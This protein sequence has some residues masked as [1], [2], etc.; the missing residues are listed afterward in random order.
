M[1]RPATAQDVKQRLEHFEQH[2]IHC[3]SPIATG[4][5]ALRLD[6]FPRHGAAPDVYD[7]CNANPHILP[8]G[9]TLKGPGGGRGKYGTP[10]LVAGTGVRSE[11]I[12]AAAAVIHHMQ[13]SSAIG[14]IAEKLQELNSATPEAGRRVIQEIHEYIRPLLNAET[15]RE[16]R[17]WIMKYQRAALRYLRS[18]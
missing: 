8:V 4:S 7:T 18:E 2:T 5:T 15:P 12:R 11:I 16:L 17:L 1:L 6:D 10:S 13:G 14:V 3:E 9:Q